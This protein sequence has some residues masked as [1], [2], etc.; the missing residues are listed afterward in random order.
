MND[1]GVIWAGIAAAASQLVPV[2]Y[3]LVVAAVL[4][5]VSGAWAAKVSGSFD[6]NFLPVWISSHGDK[7]VRILLI[8]LAAVGVGGT[9]SVA[10][11]GLITL[12]GTQAA[13]YLAG[14]VASIS[15]NVHEGLAKTKGLPS[16]V[17]A[18]LTEGDTI[19]VTNLAPVPHG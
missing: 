11:L 17:G 19:T 5:L 1:I 10:G 6:G 7:I 8:L 16:S 4:D 9:D 3:V 2:L 18:V 13:T 15:G 12:G 14:V